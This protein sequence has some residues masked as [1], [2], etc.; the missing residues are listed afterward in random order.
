[1]K[2]GFNPKVFA[3]AQFTSLA[4][5]AADYLVYGL[6]Q[7][8]LGIWYLT[9]SVAGLIAG[10]I[11]SFFMA[12][13]WAFGKGTRTVKMQA[14]LYIVVWNGNFLLNTAGVYLVTEVFH[15]NPTVSKILVSV[16]I[17]VSY[18]YLLQKKLVFK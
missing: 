15:A 2:A 11:I 18:N 6:L 7:Y 8:A 13:H 9:S 10:G 12:R 4:A 1:M 5:S 3:K 16:I 14:L 17:G